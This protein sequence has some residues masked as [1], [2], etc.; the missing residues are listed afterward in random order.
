M[1]EYSDKIIYALVASG[2]KPLASYSDFAGTFEESCI[3]YLRKIGPGTSAAVKVDDSFIIYYINE[4]NITYLIMTGNLYT[5]ETA[6]GC[7][8]SIKKEFESLYQNRTFESE[9]NFALNDEFK[10]K[11]RMKIDYFNCNT[12][13]SNEAL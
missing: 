1:S 12:D 13:V 2:A 6:I 5:K 10:V 11:L 8:E 4:N 3:L 9:S 7:L